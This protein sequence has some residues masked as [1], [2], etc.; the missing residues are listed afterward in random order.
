MEM[1]IGLQR[2]HFYPIKGSWLVMR[3]FTRGVLFPLFLLFTS[4]LI[5]SPAFSDPTPDALCTKARNGIE[6]TF[7]ALGNNL[8]VELLSCDI[9]G[10]GNATLQLKFSASG[11]FSEIGSSMFF[12]YMDNV[13]RN[14]S[15][16]VAIG[17]Y[18]SPMS[19][20]FRFP[21]FQD[22]LNAQLSLNGVE[23]LDF[24]AS[25]PSE[26]FANY[27]S[28]VPCPGYSQR[29]NYEGCGATDEVDPNGNYSL[30]YGPHGPYSGI[31]IPETF[32]LFFK[33]T[34]AVRSKL[35]RCS[36]CLSDEEFNRQ[37]PAVVEEILEQEEALFYTCSNAGTGQPGA[38][39]MASVSTSGKDKLQELEEQRCN[40]ERPSI[41]KGIDR[42][43]THINSPQGVN[44]VFAKGLLTRTPACNETVGTIA[45]LGGFE[46]PTQHRTSTDVYNG[47]L[48]NYG[49]KGFALSSLSPCKWIEKVPEGLEGILFSNVILAKKG[50]I[51]VFEKQRKPNNSPGYG[52]SCKP[53]QDQFIK[54]YQS[55]DAAGKKAAIEWFNSEIKKQFGRVDRNLM[56]YGGVEGALS[57]SYFRRTEMPRGKMTKANGKLDGL[58]NILKRRGTYYSPKVFVPTQDLEI[59]PPPTPEPTPTPECQP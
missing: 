51:W 10:N 47:A 54:K 56:Q 26:R 6:A 2:C 29:Y 20:V 24:K 40:K 3:K 48:S 38:R 7:R 30:R 49:W 8:R 41:Q 14:R 16:Q 9:S 44:S 39:A 13:P 59:N 35:P 45:R 50:H 46:M 53:L 58:I 17:G 1:L 31:G 19:P 32:D 27:N 36:K 55:S 37:L 52:K 57:K 5:V 12:L 43:V 25:G 4:Q 15:P 34:M 22:A 23:S 21:E 42:L 11:R 18:P 33:G 28:N